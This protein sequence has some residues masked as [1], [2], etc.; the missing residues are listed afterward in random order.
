[1]PLELRGVRVHPSGAAKPA[2]DGVVLELAAGEL[3]AL[4]GPNGAGK[5]TI[6]RVAAG[7]VTPDAGSVIAGGQAL[8]GFLPRERARRVALVPQGLPVIPDRSVADF[9]AGGRYAWIPRGQNA[10][11]DDARVVHDAL[12]ATALLAFADRPLDAISGGERQRALVA[13]ALAQDT[14]VLLC[15]E[16]TASLD[17]D[18]QIAVLELLDARARDGRAVVVVTHDLNLAAQFA[19]KV[20]L[21][22]DGKVVACGTPR[23]VLCEAVL[24]PVFGDHL[25]VGALATD[26]GGAPVVV[27]RRGERSR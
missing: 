10:G 19:D 14:P 5:T 16:P 12:A 13:R 22:A 26:A 23:E 27:V 20:T 7:L 17:P 3:H 9:V 18:Q 15:D 8:A 1:M 11:G 25:R 24:A 4:V 21:L 2:L 6:L